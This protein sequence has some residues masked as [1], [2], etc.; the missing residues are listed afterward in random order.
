MLFNLHFSTLY[1]ALN[2]IGNYCFHLNAISFILLL[3]SKNKY[4]IRFQ[5]LAISTNVAVTKFKYKDKNR[6]KC[7][8]FSYQ[9]KSKLEN[10]LLAVAK[11][12][13]YKNKFS[14]KQLNINSFIS[15]LK[16][17]FQCERFIA[18][19]NNKMSKFL[20]KWTPFYN[21][22]NNNQE[23][24]NNNNNNNNSNNTPGNN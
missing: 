21:Y 17:K 1:I 18:N 6:Y 2:K 10:Y 20:S 23:Q 3:L 24:T 5:Y 12:Y 13:I 15:V 9:G 7:I 8:L 14:D 19:I 11:H 16:V 22:F 4:K